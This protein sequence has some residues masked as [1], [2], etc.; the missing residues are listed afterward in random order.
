MSGLVKQLLSLC[1]ASHLDLSLLLPPCFLSDECT[2]VHTG[3]GVPTP[4]QLWMGKML[5]NNGL[6][7]LFICDKVKSRGHIALIPLPT[8]AAPCR[9]LKTQ[10]VCFGGARRRKRNRCI[11][12]VSSGWL[13]G[14]KAG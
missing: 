6:C 10:P 12:G 11:I 1:L 4:P 2:C 14:N 8:R 7:Y 3:F 5:L 13:L 9:T